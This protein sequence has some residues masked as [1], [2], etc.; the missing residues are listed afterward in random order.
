MQRGAVARSDAPRTARKRPPQQ[1]ERR[2]AE[3]HAQA[4][5]PRQARSAEGGNAPPNAKQGSHRQTAS[6]DKCVF[7]FIGRQRRPIEKNMTGHLS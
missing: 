1:H 2:A 7:F 6:L 5:P 4:T 3:R